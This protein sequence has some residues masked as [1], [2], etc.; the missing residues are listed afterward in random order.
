[1]RSAVRV[2]ADGSTMRRTDAL[3][4]LL[5]IATHQDGVVSRRQAYEAGLRADDVRRLVAGRILEEPA[6]G[7]LVVAGAVP[8][9]RRDLRIATLAGSETARVVA[10]SAASFHRLDG[11]PAGVREV[12]VPRGTTLVVPGVVV[13]EWKRYDPDQITIV[14]GLPCTN[15]ACTLADLGMV[16]PRV[17]VEKA[18]DD[19]WRRQ[20]S[21]PWIRRHAERRHRGGQRGTG[22]LLQLLDR[23]ERERRPPG[24][25]F[26]RVLEACLAVP[27]MPP[28]V[29]QHE[30]R[31]ADGSFVARVDFAVV[32]LLLGIEAHSRQHH[33]GLVPELAD[34]DRDLRAAEVGWHLV[35]LG[36]DATVDPATAARRMLRIVEARRRVL[37]R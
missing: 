18:F 37:D 28:L 26:E 32:E 10:R 8:S 25:W 27:G 12:A 33:L 31:R 30:I 3:S 7:A 21:L 16:E 34:N 24:S 2:G 23:A 17:L 11:H 36:W 22:I 5:P 29:R 4:T 1:M 15:L 19:A 14:D 13:H 20:A 35:Y 6:P 9:V